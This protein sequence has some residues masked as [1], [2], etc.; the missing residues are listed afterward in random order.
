MPV[1]DIVLSFAERNYLASATTTAIRITKRVMP[2][3]DQLELGSSN[4]PNSPSK[5]PMSSPPSFTLAEVTKATIPALVQW[6]LLSA[7]SL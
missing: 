7:Q 3:M 1:P 5:R 2:V 6:L 4:L